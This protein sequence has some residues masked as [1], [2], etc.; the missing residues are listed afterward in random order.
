MQKEPRFSSFIV[1]VASRCNLNCDYCYMYQHADQSWKNKPRSLSEEHQDL[2]AKRLVE[3]ISQTNLEEVLIVYHGGEPLLFGVDNLVNLT[4]K[5]RSQ[6]SHLKCQLDFGI[7]TNGTLLKE[8]HLHK[9]KKHGISV[10]LSIDGPKEMHDQHRLDLKNRPTFDKTFEALKLLK[11]CPEVFSGCISVI[12]P[13]TDPYKL[14]KFFDENA[15]NVIDILIPDANHVTLPKGKDERPDLYKNWLIK[16]FDCWFDHFSHIKCKYFDALLMGI[17]GRAGTTE[18]IGLG[19]VS[20]L[21]IETDGTYHDHDV[22]KITEENSSALGLSLE[23]NAI[24]EAAKS[25]KIQFHRL[26]FTL[27]VSKTLQQ[28]IQKQV[29]RKKIA[30]LQG[31]VDR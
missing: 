8:D 30:D 13:F 14:F 1:K 5:L 19:D 23:N 27:R 29:E 3:Y 16:A 26:L 6:V 25:K 17:F 20:L 15:I 24:E 28:Q 21:V 11:Q 10:S 22:L 9:F 4:E 31:V 7:Q 12:N 18:A 2:F